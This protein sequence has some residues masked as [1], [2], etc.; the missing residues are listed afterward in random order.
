MKFKNNHRFWIELSFLGALALTAGLLL[1]ARHHLLREA[2][3]RDAAALDLLVTTQELNMLAFENQQLQARWPLE[4][5]KDKFELLSRKLERQ[6]PP[7]DGDLAEAQERIRRDDHAVAQVFAEMSRVVRPASADALPASPLINTLFKGTHALTLDAARLMNLNHARLEQAGLSGYRLALGTLAALTAALTVLLA[8]FRRRFVK[9]LTERTATHERLQ[10][11]EGLAR[12]RTRFETMLQEIPVG[13]LVAEAPSGRIIL[14]NAKADAICG[15]TFPKAAS[16]EEYTRYQVYHGDRTSYTVEELPLVRALRH[17][18]RIEN[19][20]FCCLAATN[21][22]CVTL[23]VNA[24]PILDPEGRLIAAAITFSDISARRQAER[25]REAR[26]RELENERGLFEAILENAPMGL[27]ILS[28]DEYRVKWANTAYRRYLD[29]Q[30]VTGESEEAITGRRVQDV[31]LPEDQA[32]VLG[33]FQRAAAE[34]KPVTIDDYP[35]GGPSQAVAYWQTI[36]LPLPACAPT[37]APDLLMMIMDVS[38]QTLARK[39]LEGLAGRLEQINR[40]KDNFLALL[41]HEL[42]NPLAPIQN[43]LVLLH[44]Q[45]SV[46]ERQQHLLSIIERQVG[47]MTRLVDDLLDVSRISRGKIELRKEALDLAE[48]V[49]RAIEST[50]VMFENRGHVLT[51][52]LPS[53]P[54]RMVADP[55]RMVQILVNLLGNA[56]KYTEP[57]GRIWLTAQRED[58]AIAIRVRDNGLGIAPEMMTILFEPFSQLQ[59]SLKSAQGGLGLGLALVRSLAELH[60]G[61]VEVRSEGLGKGSEFTVRLPLPPVDDLPAEAADEPPETQERG[62]RVLIVEDEPDAAASMAELV[63]LWG[64]EVAVASDGPTALE[65]AQAA[66]PEVVLLDIGLPG[67]DGFETAR[68]L[69]ERAGLGS[70]LLVAV[71]GYGQSEDR[72]HSREAGIDYHFTKPIDLKALHELL[73]ATSRRRPVGKSG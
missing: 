49:N 7:P 66:P 45:G 73:S 41:G 18:E 59:C 1:H 11:L 25:E 69:R 8:V 55:A 46:S 28:G 52:E 26:M 21:G 5:W 63:E 68:L 67:M 43:S 13:L 71:S 10:H 9:L 20:E 61:G 54:V 23:S 32:G 50:H 6:T 33:S 42:R 19:E 65:R 38:A 14:A 2:C 15:H 16:L 4:Q 51:V 30:R 56:A 53:T 57:G 12:E 36:V 3:R 47:H 48:I 35:A 64:H 62:L 44:E 39:Q 27:V 70:A 40:T 24:A 17:G 29:W 72:Q 22:Q 58:G 34:G 31:L 37:A 60:G